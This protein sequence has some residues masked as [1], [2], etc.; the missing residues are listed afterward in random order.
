MHCYSMTGEGQ[1]SSLRVG[2]RAGTDS[3]HLERI[4]C[5]LPSSGGGGHSNAPK[6]PGDIAFF[7][8]SSS[9]RPLHQWPCLVLW[10]SISTKIN[11]HGHLKK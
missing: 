8:V 2:V 6:G 4:V 9:T 5:V 7:M 3:S 11:E 1:A 10:E